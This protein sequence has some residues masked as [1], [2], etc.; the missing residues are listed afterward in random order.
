MVST[1]SDIPAD[2]QWSGWRGGGLHGVSP[3][4]QLPTHWQPEAG[5][6]WKQRIPGQGNSSPVIWGDQI[7]LTST[8]RQNNES[9]ATVLCYD[10]TNG[11]L[12]WE[13]QVGTPQGISHIKNGHASATITTDGQRLF[14]AFGGLGLFAFDMHGQ[15][16]WQYLLPQV[17]HQWG[18]AASPVLFENLVIHTTDGE[19]GADLIACDQATGSEVWRTARRSR[20]SWCSPVLLNSGSES[21][22]AWQ[23]VINGTGSASGSPGEVIAYDPRSGA[24]LWK[25]AGTTD[26]PCPTAIAGAGLLVSATGGNG[27]ILAMKAD[28]RGDVTTTH[29]AW[30]LASGGPYVPTGVIYRERLYLITDGGVATC[31]S[32]SDGA[33]LWRKRLH[34][35][36]SASL[37]AGGGNLYAV[38]ERGD[39]YVFQ[40]ADRFELVATNR[41]HEPCLATPAIAQGELFLRTQQHLYCV[42]QTTIAAND[43]DSP[44]PIAPAA[45]RSPG[46]VETSTLLS[47]P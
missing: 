38:S 34:G 25:V 31:H 29:L 14:A 37:I 27:P 12:L 15:P 9:Q 3:A 7:F 30:K 17:K 11:S 44:A 10:R 1:A 46:D 40:A 23:V 13:Q 8:V 4:E 28:G 43:A 19:H 20:G 42:T 39:A 26:I 18:Q 16:L 41:L 21:A 22:P 24:E 2:E 33:V 32:L 36:F 45:I 47:E 35:A 5:V 6:R